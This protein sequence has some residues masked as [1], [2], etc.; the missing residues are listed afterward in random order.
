ME[1]C[2]LPG[3]GCMYPRFTFLYKRKGQHIKNSY[4][5]TS[6]NVLISSDNPKY[7]LSKNAGLCQEIIFSHLVL[8]SFICR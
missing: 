6:I 8:V 2:H 4:N 7:H 1:S 3:N 5:G